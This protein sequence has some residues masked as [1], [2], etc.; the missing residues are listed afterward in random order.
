[1]PPVYDYTCTTCARQ[2]EAR[3]SVA[4]SAD[5][6]CTTCGSGARRH[7]P[8]PEPMIHTYY[9]GKKRAGW[10]D[11]KKISKLRLRRLNTQD[12]E[13]IAAIN[14]EM[15]E[16]RTTMKTDDIPL[17][18]SAPKSEKPIGTGDESSMTNTGESL[19]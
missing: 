12:K 10:E 4:A 2:F 5:V 13:E 17:G 16:R 8:A 1:M 11:L 14:K 15:L 3:V 9:D 18:M 6:K 7:F 19:L